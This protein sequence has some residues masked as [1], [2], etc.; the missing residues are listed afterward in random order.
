MTGK[1]WISSFG[2]MVLV[3]TWLGCETPKPPPPF[4]C[5]DDVV[6]IGDTLTINLLDVPDPP[7]DRLFV[8]ASDG[9]VF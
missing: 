8:V 7:V 4:V 5:I 6:R 9:T 2:L 3:A 1:G